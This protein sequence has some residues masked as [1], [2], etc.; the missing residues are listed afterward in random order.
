MFNINIKKIVVS[1]LN[2]DIKARKNIEELSF[3]VNKKKTQHVSRRKK[4]EKRKRGKKVKQKIEKVMFLSEDSIHHSNEIH[5]T[6][7]YDFDYSRIP[8]SFGTVG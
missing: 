1:V 5:I 6:H 4:S 7:Y 2:A 8:S 3:V